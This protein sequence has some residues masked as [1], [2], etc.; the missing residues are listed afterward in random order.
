MKKEKEERLAEE[1]SSFAFLSLLGS[2]FKSNVAEDRFSSFSSSSRSSD[3]H[4]LCRHQI[5]H[6]NFK[7]TTIKE[8]TTTMTEQRQDGQR[9][10]SQEPTVFEDAINITIGMLNVIYLWVLGALMVFVPKSLRQ[11]SVQGKNVLITGGGSGI[12]RLMAINL[13]AKGANVIIWDINPE[14]LKST[15]EDL[16]SIRKDGKVVT[17]VVDVSSREEVYEKAADVKNE[18]GKFFPY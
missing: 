10:Q 15:K 18:L 8:L 17:M 6:F 2:A 4:H 11:K 7:L 9:R 1:D 3:R 13:Y 16:L 5:H 12:G 14:G